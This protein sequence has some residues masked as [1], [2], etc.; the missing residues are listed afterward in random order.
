MQ[1]TAIFI[2][3]FICFTSFPSP[4]SAFCYRVHCISKKKPHFVLFILING[5]TRIPLQNRAALCLET[6]HHLH[7][8][9]PAY[10]TRAQKMKKWGVERGGRL[11]FLDTRH[12]H[13]FVVSDKRKDNMKYK[14]HPVSPFTRETPRH[15][16]LRKYI[17]NML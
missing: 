6:Q 8:I 4:P 15:P 7:R 2:H 1:K 5:F 11:L 17:I 3:W 13:M 16:A 10:A 12:L 14:R 9:S